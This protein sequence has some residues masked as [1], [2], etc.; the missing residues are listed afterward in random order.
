[1]RGPW[2]PVYGPV[3]L[4]I[5]EGG[6]TVL[7]CPPG[8]ART[9]LLMTLA[10]RMRPVEGSLTVFGMTNARESFAVSALAGIEDIDSVP[11]SVTVRDLLTEKL[12]WNASW[13]KLIWRADDTDLKRVCEP[14]FGDLPL[15]HLDA[16]VD[17]LT[18]LDETL[19]RV[20]LANTTEPRLL[21]V[22]SLDAVA[23]DGDRALLL[24]RL[25]ELGAS[26]T[27]IT[28]AANPQGEAPGCTQIPVAITEPA[29]L[30]GQQKGAR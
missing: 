12:R 19:L 11:E 25:I 7:I 16:F 23:V 22:G 5:A 24:D 15:P 27:V 21:V 3:D 28:S 8:T 9:A 13:Y 20:A 26:Q 29:E 18:E 14:V 4:D 30:A 17:Q 6:V 1:M 10:S 2:G